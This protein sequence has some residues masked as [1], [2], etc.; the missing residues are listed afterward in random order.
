MSEIRS[1]RSYSE[2]INEINEYIEKKLKRGEDEVTILY[3][4]KAKL[5]DYIRF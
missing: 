3:D 4:L 5:M 1:H 2:A